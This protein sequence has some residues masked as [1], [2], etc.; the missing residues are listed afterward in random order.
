MLKHGTQLS[1]LLTRLCLSSPYAVSASLRF[2]FLIILVLEWD[3]SGLDDALYANRIVTESRDCSF[4]ETPVLNTNL[5]ASAPVADGTTCS[6][7]RYSL[8]SVFNLWSRWIADRFPDRI[9]QSDV[10]MI[11][12]D[13]EM[14]LLSGSYDILGS[15]TQSTKTAGKIAN[16]G[17]LT[18]LSDVEV[19]RGFATLLIRILGLHFRYNATLRLF[20]PEPIPSHTFVP[21]WAYLDVQSQDIFNA[22]LAKQEANSTE[23]TALPLPT[24]TSTSSFSSSSTSSSS[25]V[26]APS[27]TSNAPSVEE[28]RQDKISGGIVGG[29]LGLAG[30]CALF[31]WLRSRRN[32]HEGN[33]LSPTVSEES[34]DSKTLPTVVVSTVPYNSSSTAS[35]V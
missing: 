30:L 31:W 23:S 29:V 25:L 26:P 10:S 4:A 14:I 12:Y 17:L 11:P 13:S 27:S 1:A 32:R 7:L 6:E 33:S 34:K 18:Q 21:G 5:H 19:R 20:Y 8:A 28:D 9:S 22:D 35:P 2:A 16:T 3:P 24:S 15:G